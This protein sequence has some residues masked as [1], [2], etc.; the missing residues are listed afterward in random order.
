MHVVRSFHVPIMP[1]DP[2]STIDRAMR[3]LGIVRVAPIARADLADSPA[4]VGPFDAIASP[5]IHTGVKAMTQSYETPVVIEEAVLTQVTG[6]A[7]PSTPIP[8]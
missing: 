7:N 2:I 1:R 6:G 8:G 4:D 5:P 3:R